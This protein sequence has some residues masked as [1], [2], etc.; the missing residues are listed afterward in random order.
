VSRVDLDGRRIDFRLV[1]EGEERVARAMK[2]K[3]LPPEGTER[4]F[5][6]AV[7]PN[8]SRRRASKKADAAQAR[9]HPSPIQALKA[10]AKKESGR[11]E[12]GK[13]K[14]RKSRR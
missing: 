11:S 4:R 7:S 2:D 12:S 5:D 6:E 10:A 13:T 8:G 1:H 3:G 14:S 9:A